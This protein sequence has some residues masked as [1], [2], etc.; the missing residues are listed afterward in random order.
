MTRRE[1]IAQ[2]ERKEE[3]RLREKKK[4]P[5]IDIETEKFLDSLI[6][7]RKGRG[8]ATKNFFPDWRKSLKGPLLML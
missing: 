1:R 6:R 3:N 5:D 7:T 4:Q 2:R 8:A